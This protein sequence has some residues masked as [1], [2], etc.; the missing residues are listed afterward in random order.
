MNQS[1]RIGIGMGDMGDI[2]IYTNSLTLYVP[3]VGGKNAPPPQA[4]LDISTERVTRSHTFFF[5]L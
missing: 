5:T 3:G 1:P 2:S 4:L